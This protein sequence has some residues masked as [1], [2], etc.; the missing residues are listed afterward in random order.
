MTPSYSFTR[1]EVQ[2]IKAAW[3]TDAGRL[4]LQLVVER[5]GN[6][7]GASFDTDPILMAF[8]EGRRFVARELATAINMPIEK[9]VKEQHDDSVRISEPISATER[10]AR[11]ASGGWERGGAKRKR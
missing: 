9:I 8:N 3:S 2:I 7:H 6:M 1:D 10:A 5:L 11:V 4:A